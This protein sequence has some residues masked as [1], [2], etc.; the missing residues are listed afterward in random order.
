M[1]GAAHGVTSVSGTI[2]R[3]SS[4]QEQG[5]DRDHR[6]LVPNTK[7]SCRRKSTSDVLKWLTR[8]GVSRSRARKL[9]LST[10]CE[11]TESLAVYLRFQLPPLWDAN[12]DC[13]NTDMREMFGVNAA[14]ARRI[15]QGLD[16]MSALSPFM[17][18]RLTASLQCLSS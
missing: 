4:M 3:D 2:S 6:S 5:E 18:C 17:P 11:S 9:L 13:I 16:V 10:G 1:N 15:I 7:K 12:E 14:N 8:R